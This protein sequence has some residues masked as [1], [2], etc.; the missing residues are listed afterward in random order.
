MKAR[1]WLAFLLLALA[2][3]GQAEERAPVSY[4]VVGAGEP[5][6]LPVAQQLLAHLA[7]GEIDEAALLSNEPNRRTEVLRD[8]LRTVGEA[9]FRRVYAQYLQPPNRMAREIAI[10]PRRLLIWQ[11][12]DRLAGQY[13]IESD[14]GF[15]LDDRPGPERRALQAL[16]AQERKERGAKPATP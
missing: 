12:G 10:G 2:G 4:R 14:G 7:A 1:L 15:L 5:S 13:Y 8:Y 11:L 16:L 6:A 9:E 3:G